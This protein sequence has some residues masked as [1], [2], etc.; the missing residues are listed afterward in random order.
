M[1]VVSSLKKVQSKDSRGAS[2]HS[3]RLVFPAVACFPG[4]SFF[5]GSTIHPICELSSSGA[6]PFY[7][8]LARYKGE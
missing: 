4:A 6:L 7:M 3:G 8:T 1:F 5:E 2:S